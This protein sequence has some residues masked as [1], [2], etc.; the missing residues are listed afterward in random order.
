VHWV[1]LLGGGWPCIGQRACRQRHSGGCCG[2]SGGVV[3]GEAA[4]QWTRH[5][6]GGRGEKM[7][8]R[9]TRG[10]LATAL[11]NSAVVQRAVLLG[12]RRRCNGRQGGMQR[13]ASILL[14]HG[15]GQDPLEGGD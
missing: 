2:A 4:V 6:G 14:A 12:E 5:G 11:W 8:Q 13:C 9:T 7:V 1:V 15:H 3:R 10:L